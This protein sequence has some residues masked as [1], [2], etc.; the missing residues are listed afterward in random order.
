MGGVPSVTASSSANPKQ[1][2]FDD[3]NAAPNGLDA[4]AQAVFE[5]DRGNFYGFYV[6]NNTASNVFLQVFDQATAAGVTVGTDKPNWT[7]RIP[8]GGSFGKDANDT[9][10]RFMGAG[11]IV[12]VTT[13]RT[14][15]GSPATKATGTFWFK[16]LNF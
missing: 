11:L 7:A 3:G 6:E 2:Y 5:S 12:A 13:T 16:Q 8:A 1:K 9:P 14:G 10:L 15:S 4:T